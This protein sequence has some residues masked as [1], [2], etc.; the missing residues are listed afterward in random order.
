MTA[1]RILV[2]NGPNLNLLG[3]REPEIYGSASLGDI[4]ALLATAA[5]KIGAELKIA[6]R[7]ECRQSNSESDL[8]GW[9]GEA[10]GKFE[11]IIINPAAFTHT[12]IGLLDAIKAVAPND[13]AGG[14]PCVEVHLSNTQAREEF[15]QKSL[16]AQGCIGQVSGFQARSYV[17]AL[18]GIVHYILDSMRADKKQP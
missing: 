18:Q 14:V 9:I 8:I 3:K 1:V 15:R 16:T 13:G 10:P 6:V 17:L 2:L 12:S 4:D 11:G 7:V 5:G